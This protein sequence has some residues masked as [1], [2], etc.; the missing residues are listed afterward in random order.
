MNVKETEGTRGDW[1]FLCLKV[2][3]CWSLESDT[4]GFLVNISRYGVWL[5][6]ILED[7]FY[8]ALN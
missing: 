7:E 2:G 3:N 6:M 4:S 1:V 5:G 8:G